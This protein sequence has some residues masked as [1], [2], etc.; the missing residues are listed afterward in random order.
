MLIANAYAQTANQDPSGGLIGLLPIILMF[1]VL[2]FLM[3]RPQMKRAKEHQK[4]V[5]E[6]QVGDEV[7]TQGGITGKIAK[8]GDN[9]VTLVI[10]EIKEGPVEV[11]L[12]KQAV[13]ALLP[14][15]ALKTLQ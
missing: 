5:S 12:Q 7:V 3:I 1:I 13:S 15:G 6:L 11:L 8:V 14:K 9:Y 4:I 2:W 10:A